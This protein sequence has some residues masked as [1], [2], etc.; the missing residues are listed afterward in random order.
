[1]ANNKKTSD[2][3]Y[4]EMAKLFSAGN[5][6]ADIGR[7]FGV[8]R[9]AIWH[10]LNAGGAVKKVLPFIFVDGIRFT[11]RKDGY[12]T[13]TIAGKNML[14]HRYVYEKEHGSI[15]R[16]H[17]VHHID[18]DKGNNK[19]GNLVLLTPIEHARTHGAFTETDGVMLKVCFYCKEE[20]PLSDSY[21]KK[22]KSVGIFG[23]ERYESHCILCEPAVQKIKD[24]QRDKELRRAW[25]KEYDAG[26][27]DILS[28]RKR[29]NRAVNHDKVIAQQREHRANNKEKI[30]A[31]QRERR[32]RNIEQARAYDREKY[33]RRKLKKEQE[34]T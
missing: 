26:R 15:P 10:I 8:S 13:G 14:V 16:G 7:M 34:N 23:E 4:A 11:L 19:I 21:F 28:A 20:K 25:E 18:G 12:Y 32:Q 3:K 6:Y 24:G 1:M 9:Q 17:N 5:S 33:K 29:E 22:K 30:N 31:Q 27:L 2:E